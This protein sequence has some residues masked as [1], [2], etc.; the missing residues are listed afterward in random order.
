MSRLESR[1]EK[2]GR[3]ELWMSGGSMAQPMRQL[4]P[5]VKEKLVSHAFDLAT[6]TMLKN[7]KMSVLYLA[8][9]LCG[10]EKK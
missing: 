6:P 3:H 8:T 7:G 9:S 10:K 4:G 2:T 5:T 1:R